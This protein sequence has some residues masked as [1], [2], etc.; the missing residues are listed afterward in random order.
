VNPTAYLRVLNELKSH[1]DI[2]VGGYVK[3][4]IS[5]DLC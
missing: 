1:P 4:R 5:D 3:E 2:N